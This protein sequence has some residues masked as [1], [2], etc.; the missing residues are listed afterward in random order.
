MWNESI[1]KTLNKY[2]I[3]VVHSMCTF[4]L[5]FLLIKLITALYFLSQQIQLFWAYFCADIWF[6]V[7]G[8]IETRA[9]MEDAAKVIVDKL[10]FLL[11]AETSTLTAAMTLFVKT[12]VRTNIKVDG[13]WFFE[14]RIICC[15]YFTV[16]LLIL[17]TMFQLIFHYYY[18]NEMNS[19]YYT[20]MLLLPDISLN[21]LRKSVTEYF[22]L[23]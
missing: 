6:L 4:L 18:L 3:D 12:E 8:E 21:L 20:L 2:Y 5:L 19:N 16:V 9:Q 7:G 22:C 15:I 11:Q 17:G 13:H 10:S 14:N 1:L 23:F